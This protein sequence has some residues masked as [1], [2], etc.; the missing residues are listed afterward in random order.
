MKLLVISNLFPF[1]DQPSRGIF[2]ANQFRELPPDFDTHVLVPVPFREWRRKYAQAQSWDRLKVRYLPFVYPPGIAQGWHGETM[3][4]SILAGARQWLAQLAPEIVLGSFLYPDGYAA[5]RVAGRL[6]CPLVLKAHGSDVNQKGH[7]P[8]LRR[9][10]AW[11]LQRADALVVVSEALRGELAALG[12]NCQAVQVIGNGVDTVAF[13]PRD[14]GTSRA[15]LGLPADERLVLFAG[16]LKA[17]KGAVDAVRV[18]CRLNE[19]GTR[20]RLVIVGD[21]TAATLMRQAAVQRGGEELLLW[22]G[23]RAHSELPAYMNAVDL[24]LLP[25]HAEGVPNVVLEALACGIPVVASAVGGIPEVLR[26]SAGALVPAG[27]IAAFALACG[28]VL[29]RCFDRDAIR[30]QVMQRSW[31]GSA[32]QLAAV[33]RGAVARAAPGN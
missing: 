19:S 20:A 12:L 5:A 14:R 10:I 16:N 8:A 30:A 23:R 13:A 25:S 31:Q 4:L 1:P 26:D 21:G 15:Q 2:N 32:A 7:R 9:R 18:V 6:H 28:A 33:L 27:D 17:D 3:Y 22:Q 24:L 11:A 29:T